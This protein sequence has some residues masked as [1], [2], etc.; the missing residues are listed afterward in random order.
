MGAKKGQ[1]NDGRSTDIKFSWLTKTMGIEYKLW[2]E[3]ASQ[4]MEKQKVSISD[5]LSALTWFFTSYIPNCAPYA[6]S[7]IISFFSGWN[8]HISS[9]DEMQ[10][11][12]K[13][14]G[15]IDSNEITRRI[16]IC[17][18]FIDS[19]VLENFSELDDYNNI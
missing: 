11:Y 3:L 2:Q 6:S 13:E 17:C 9:T 15:V 7:D 16:N 5:K 18:N 19:V 12:L 1:K 14:N 10:R 4:W 8:G